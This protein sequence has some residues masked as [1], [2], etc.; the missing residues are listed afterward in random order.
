MS[1]VVNDE[2]GYSSK[3]R[4]RILDAVDELGYRPNMLARGLITRRSGTVGLSVADITDPFFTTL[5]EGVESR[6][7][8]Q[9]RTTF[10]AS[11]EGDVGRQLEVLKSF[12]AHSVDGMV[13]SPLRECR[14]Q[15]IDYARRGMP[16]VVVDFPL[17]APRTASVRFDI[18]NGARLAVE[19]LLGIGRRRLAM[20]GVSLPVPSGPPGEEGFLRA[21]AAASGVRGDLVRDHPTVKGGSAGMAHL[22]QRQPNI[23]GLVAYNDAMAIGAMSAARAHGRRVPEDIAIIGFDDIEMSAHVTPALT[24]VRLDRAPLADA[25]TFA[26]HQLIEDGVERPE[27]VLLPAE[28]ILRGSA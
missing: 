5:A 24:T 9:G 6:V 7:R 25:I 8:R 10:F 20:I 19:H 23:D 13:V 1:R 14:E 4:Q 27:P 11:A 12:W 2:G 3:T 28:L 21:V 22:L 16:T 18:S 15:L 26:L 17:D